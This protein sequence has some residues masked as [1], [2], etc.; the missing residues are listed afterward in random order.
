[1]KMSGALPLIIAPSDYARWL[2]EQPDPHD[3][4]QGR[5]QKDEARPSH[6]MKTPQE[7]NHPALVLAKNANG[8][9]QEKHDQHQD[10]HD[11]H[12]ARFEVHWL[13]R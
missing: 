12:A 6:S 10:H 3:L 8:A 9:G 7:K 2:G 13:L 1:M 5:N 11:D 4:L